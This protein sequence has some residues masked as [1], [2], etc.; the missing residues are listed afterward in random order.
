MIAMKKIISAF[1]IVLAGV[2]PL[3]AEEVLCEKK[4]GPTSCSDRTKN[5]DV[6]YNTVSGCSGWN[7]NG[8]EVTTFDVWG[9]CSPN[10]G[11]GAFDNS[12][13]QTPTGVKKATAAAGKYCYC[14]IKSINGSAVASSPRWVFEHS[15]SSVSDCVSSC[16]HDC[17]L[18]ARGNYAGFRFTLISAM[19]NVSLGE[20]LVAESTC[21][22]GY[23]KVS[24]T[25]TSSDSAGSFT[26][27]CEDK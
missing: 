25:T 7:Y 2:S 15:F 22:D 14:Q 6:D 19:L 10:E 9:G 27:T 26:I 21:P 24:G 16:A 12:I 23:R 13:V 5:H 11:I 4:I 18:D 8:S 3:Q 17:A 20:S 1:I